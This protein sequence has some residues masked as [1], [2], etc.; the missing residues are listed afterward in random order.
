M[1]DF[2]APWCGPCRAISPI[3]EQIVTKYE[4]GAE[5]G[6]EGVGFYKVNIDDC[7]DIAQ[8]VGIRTV[9]RILDGFSKSDEI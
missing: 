5:K 9:C 7:Q 4:Q 8:E 1:I 2:W 6:H 3:F